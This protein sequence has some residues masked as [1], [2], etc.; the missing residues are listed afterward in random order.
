[1]SDQFI[2][3]RYVTVSS[4]GQERWYDHY[5]DAHAVAEDEGLCVLEYEYEE[6]SREFIIH[7]GH[8]PENCE[9]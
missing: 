5:D 4:E 8:E 3:R 2:T 6:L 7:A 9:R 1:M